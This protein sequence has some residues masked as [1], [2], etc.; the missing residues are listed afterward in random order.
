MERLASLGHF[1]PDSV[2]LDLGCG[3]GVNAFYLAQRFGCRVLGVDISSEMLA[4]ARGVLATLPEQVRSKV[5]GGRGREEAGS[6]GSR[7][8]QSRAKLTRIGWAGVFL[9]REPRQPG[10]R[11]ILSQGLTSPP[12][13]K[14]APRA[15][16]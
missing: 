8:S 11:H 9:S 16:L 1:T 7:G 6:K 3:S 15:V 10:R 2:V 14:T 4:H 12:M 13:R 5:R